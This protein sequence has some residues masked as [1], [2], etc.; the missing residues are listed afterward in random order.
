MEFGNIKKPRKWLDIST[1]KQNFVAHL[2][3]ITES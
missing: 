3:V 1:D 2:P